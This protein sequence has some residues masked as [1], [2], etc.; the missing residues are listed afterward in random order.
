MQL[1]LVLSCV[2]LV[3]AGFS[4]FGSRHVG[5]FSFFSRNCGKPPKRALCNYSFS[6]APKNRLF[7]P[8][9]CRYSGFSEFRLKCLS[10]SPLWFRQLRALCQ[11]FPN[12]RYFWLVFLVL[13]G[14][15]NFLGLVS[16]SYRRTRLSACFGANLGTRQ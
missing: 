6:Q 8:L 11:N 2:C 9:W 14:F 3:V 1:C 12:F 10:S 5:V 4:S 15:W 13:L 7:G 16:A